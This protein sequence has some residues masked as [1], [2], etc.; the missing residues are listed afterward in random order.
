MIAFEATDN[1]I[2]SLTSKQEVSITV[3]DVPNPTSTNDVLIGDIITDPDLTDTVINPYMANLKKVNKFI[4]SNKI[5][6]AINQVFAFI[7]KI[8]VD[9]LNGEIDGQTGSDLIL[10]AEN[11]LYD[12]GED[13][14]KRECN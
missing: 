13:P 12:L 4:G 5:T 2:E 10:Q 1:D 8:Q 7:C 9:I 14:N 3:G 11:I 6:S